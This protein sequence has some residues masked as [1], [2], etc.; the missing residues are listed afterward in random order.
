MSETPLDVRIRVTRE[1]LDRFEQA[2]QQSDHKDLH[3][4]LGKAI[5]DGL[6]SQIL[7]LNAEHDRLLMER[8][9]ADLHWEGRL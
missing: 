9:R 3:P 2:L 5:D 7:D 8:L 4:L 1:A 6:R